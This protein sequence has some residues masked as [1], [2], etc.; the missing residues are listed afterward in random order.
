ML[1]LRVITLFSVFALSVINA[2]ADDATEQLLDKLSP[3]QQLQG[4]FVQQQFDEQGEVLLESSGNFKL[5]RPAY[6][7]WEIDSP[8]RQ[9][10]IADPEFLWH[11]DMDLETVTR[12]PV[13]DSVEASPLQV[14]TGDAAGLSENFEVTRASE[15]SFTLIPRDTEQN[16]REL[17]VRFVDH[18]LS[19]LDIV[20]RL[21][22][23]VTVTLIDLDNTPSLTPDAFAF[24]PPEGE[25]D[26]F[27]YDD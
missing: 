3:I 13:N 26:V 2:Q 21:G 12:R 17:T 18:R 19:Q 9:L 8:D 4:R 22:Q 27:Y 10:I 1:I 11:Y 16:F 24:T 5:L 6:F 14:L 7:S 23:Q 25:V 15:D 20:D